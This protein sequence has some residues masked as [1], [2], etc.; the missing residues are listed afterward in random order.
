[1]S[2]LS[3]TGFQSSFSKS[4]QA[5]MVEKDALIRQLRSE[6]TDLRSTAGE[7]DKISRDY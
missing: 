3:A 5:N 6:I 4:R 2:N 1:M 7:Y